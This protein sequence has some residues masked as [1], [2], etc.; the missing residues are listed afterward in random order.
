M[1][2]TIIFAACREREQLP[3]NPEMPADLFTSCLTTPIKVA[4]RFYHMEYRHILPG[5][6]SEELLLRVPGIM[7]D[8]RTML[9]EIAWLFAAITDTIAW[10]S[11]S[12]DLFQRLFR[13]DVITAS[14]ARNFLLAQRV[15]YYFEC[16]PVCWPNLPSMQT[17]RLWQVSGLFFSGVRGRH[18]C[19]RLG[20]ELLGTH[21]GRMPI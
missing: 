16:N 6:A 3:L 8:R 10:N 14:L 5:M 18:G 1:E 20:Q 13:Q 9:G 19:M 21:S 11:M 12:I 4:L 7:T 2:N 17:H 15:M